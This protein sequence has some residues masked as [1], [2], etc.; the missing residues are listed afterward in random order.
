M[1]LGQPSICQYIMPPLRKNYSQFLPR[2]VFENF[3]FSPMSQAI[4]TGVLKQGVTRYEF[5][6]IEFVENP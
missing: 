4:P 2:K 1:I 6:L 5:K 3:T